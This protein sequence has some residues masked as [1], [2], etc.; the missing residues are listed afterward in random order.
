VMID[1]VVAAF[2]AYVV[3]VITIVIAYKVLG[4]A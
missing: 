1:D 4:F 2:Y 3:F